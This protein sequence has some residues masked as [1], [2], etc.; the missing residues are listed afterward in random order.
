MDGDS[1]YHS[2]YGNKAAYIQAYRAG[3][4]AGYRQSYGS[5]RW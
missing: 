5:G 2:S 1:G 4:M 3:W